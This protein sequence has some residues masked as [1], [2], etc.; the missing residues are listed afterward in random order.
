MIFASKA[1]GSPKHFGRMYDKKVNL[2]GL[3]S[4]MSLPEQ[5]TPAQLQ[6]AWPQLMAGTMQ[7]LTGLKEQQ[8]SLSKL[9]LMHVDTEPDMR[10]SQSVFDFVRFCTV[11]Q[12]CMHS[13][14]NIQSMHN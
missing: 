1:G 5:S 6:S 10:E 7:L 12:K 14:G 4:I 8:V 9:S 11:L 2:L 3:I 13:F